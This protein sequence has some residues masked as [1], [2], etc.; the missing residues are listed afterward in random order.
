TEGNIILEEQMEL[1][2]GNFPLSIATADLNMDFTPEIVVSNWEVEGL[3]VIHNFLPVD[4]QT[5]NL[6]YDI[7]NDGVVNISD[8]EMLLSFVIVG[9]ESVSAADINFDS[10]VDIFDLLLLSDYLQDM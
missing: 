6:P 1:G 2:I 3:R 4:E 9:N 10:E 5:D 8:F 7:N